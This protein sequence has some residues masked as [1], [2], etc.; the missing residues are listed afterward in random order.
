MMGVAPGIAELLEEAAHRDER[1][2]QGVSQWVE[3][4][5]FAAMEKF[6]EALGGRWWR[7]PQ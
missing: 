6:F 5:A 4:P 7:R 3:H 2:A 1:L